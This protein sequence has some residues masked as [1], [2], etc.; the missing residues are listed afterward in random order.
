MQPQP[1][2]RAV[3]ATGIVTIQHPHEGDPTIAAPVPADSW[4]LRLT[5]PDASPTGATIQARCRV[6]AVDDRHRPPTVDLELLEVVDRCR[7]Q[8]S[9]GTTHPALSRSAHHS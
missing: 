3:G 1:W 2:I 7:T 4:R 8:P 9:T 6:V 5:N